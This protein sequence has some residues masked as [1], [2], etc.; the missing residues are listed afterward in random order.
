M[1]ENLGVFAWLAGRQ[2]EEGA[3]DRA[4]KVSW[5]WAREGPE[6]EPGKASHFAG[7]AGEARL[8]FMTQQL[9]GNGKEGKE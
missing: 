4:G 3:Q 5:R 8:C 7:V 6:M 1:E 9:F 2:S